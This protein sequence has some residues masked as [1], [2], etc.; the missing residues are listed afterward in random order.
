M[1]IFPKNTCD[2]WRKKHTWQHHHQVVIFSEDSEL[3]LSF[4]IGHQIHQNIGQSTVIP[5]LLSNTWEYS[6][7]WD[8]LIFYL[9]KWSTLPETNIAPENGWLEY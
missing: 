1:G 8:D 9:K 2:I 5:T 4:P 3:F 7:L 6:Y